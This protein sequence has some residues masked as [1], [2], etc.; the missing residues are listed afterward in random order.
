MAIAQGGLILKREIPL[1]VVDGVNTTFTTS[2]SYIP[3]TL[4]V[5]LNGMLLTP[6]VGEDYVEVD[7]TTF[8]MTVAPG[9]EGSYTDKLTVLYQ[10][11]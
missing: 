2:R 1:G 6:G 5:F 9:V 10:L 4:M 3:N 7:S 11:A 8:S